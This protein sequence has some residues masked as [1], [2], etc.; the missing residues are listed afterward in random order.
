MPIVEGQTV[1]GTLPDLVEDLTYAGCVFDN[2]H[3]RGGVM[4]NV[5]F[6]DCA[7]WATSFSDVVFDGCLI[8]N[9]KTRIQTS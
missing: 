3:Q 8:Q 9:M 7:A 2:C 4:R 6:I 1:R 5:Q